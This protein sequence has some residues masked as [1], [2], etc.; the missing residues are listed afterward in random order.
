MELFGELY[1]E[2]FGEKLCSSLLGNIYLFFIKSLGV[3]RGLIWSRGPTWI[4][5]IYNIYVSYQNKW[6]FPREY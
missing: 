3:I 5:D 4:R 2:N 6:I 1:V